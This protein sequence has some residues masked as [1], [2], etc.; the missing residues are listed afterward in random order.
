VQVLE[1]EDHAIKY[2]VSGMLSEIKGMITA[3]S[4]LYRA[5]LD[6]LH[7]HGVE[8]VSPS[9]MNQRRYPENLKIIPKP[10][11]TIVDDSSAT[12]EDIAF[13]KAEKAERTENTRE[14]LLES[15]QLLEASLKLADDDKKEAI[16]H[17]IK[18]IRSRLEVIEHHDAQS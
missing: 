1:L 11:G 6:T 9:F 12:A 16:N 4:R 17:R 8:I 18:T 7:G 2:R 3:R 10:K 14:L 5:V 15:L 13:E